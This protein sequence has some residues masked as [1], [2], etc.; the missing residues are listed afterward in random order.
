MPASPKY[1]KTSG[2]GMRSIMHSHAHLAQRTL[3]HFG[4]LHTIHV[5]QFGPNVMVGMPFFAAFR[6]S[7]PR[8]LLPLMRI[9]SVMAPCLRPPSGLVRLQRG[10]MDNNTSSSFWHKDFGRHDD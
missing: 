8:A 2:L 5:A 3:S 6:R 9:Q 4:S 10:S 7:W 1:A